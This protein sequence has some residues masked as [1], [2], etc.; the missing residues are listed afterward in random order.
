MRRE[1]KQA[2]SSWSLVLDES[3]SQRHNRSGKQQERMT[4]A[5]GCMYIELE[6]LAAGEACLRL[7]RTTGTGGWGNIWVAPPCPCPS[8]M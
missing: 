4:G 5:G 1:I 8:V 2:A 7:R 3:A 6:A